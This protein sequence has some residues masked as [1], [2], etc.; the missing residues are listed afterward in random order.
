MNFIKKIFENQMDEKVHAQ[1]TRF[2]KGTL[3]DKALLD[4]NVQAI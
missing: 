1:F 3:E 2:G 4:I